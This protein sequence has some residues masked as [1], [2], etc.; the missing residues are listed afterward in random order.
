MHLSTHCTSS[1]LVLA[2]A[3]P[4]LA[5]IV[6]LP[7]VRQ[8]VANCILTHGQTDGN[9]GIRSGIKKLGFPVVASAAV[10]HDLAYWCELHLLHWTD[11]HD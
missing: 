9:A 1:S 8:T 5:A 10:N 2:Q 6:W 11:L 3:I 4:A 7:F